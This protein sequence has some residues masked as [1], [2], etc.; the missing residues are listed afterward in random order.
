VER[1]NGEQLSIEDECS[2]QSSM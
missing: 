1:F 2:Q